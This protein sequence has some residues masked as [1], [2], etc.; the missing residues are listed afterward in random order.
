LR[1]TL[2]DGS[3]VREPNVVRQR[4]WPCDI[5]QNKA[6][7]LASQYNLNLG[8]S[9]V[10]IP[11]SFPCDETAWP[12]ANADIVVT[13]VDVNSARRAVGNYDGR[14]RRDALWLD[15]GNGHRHGQA[16]LGALH[17]ALRKRFPS[18]LEEYP[19]VESLADSD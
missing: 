19:E 5:G 11:R 1:V 18:V 2:I 3:V 4:F 16:V 17:S 14:V 7:A 15:L 13:C 8:T 6:V 12:L 10:A 9:W